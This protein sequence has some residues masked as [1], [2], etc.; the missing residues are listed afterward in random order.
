[1]A[2]S[3]WPRSLALLLALV[4]PASAPGASA[5]GNKLAAPRGDVAIDVQVG[6]LPDSVSRPPRDIPPRAV[7]G[8]AVV[9]GRVVDD[10]GT[11]IG[12]ARV[13]VPLP[14]PDGQRTVITGADGRY[15]FRNLP[16][17]TLLITATRTGYTGARWSREAMR[18]VT[19]GEG[20]VRDDVDLVLVRG[21]AIVGHVFDPAGEPLVGA[22]V[23]AHLARRA[24]RY[25]LP[26][27]AGSNDTTDDRGAF[28]LHSLAPGDYYVSV[29]PLRSPDG[30]EDGRRDGQGLAP[31]YH[32]GT[33][34]VSA[35]RAITVV[36]N[37]E[38]PVAMTVPLSP[39]FAVTG[40]VVDR[41]GRAVEDAS[42]SLRP[43]STIDGLP[44]SSGVSLRPGGAF[45]A[46]R[47]APGRYTLVARQFSAGGTVPVQTT[48]RPPPSGEVDLDVSSDIDGVVVRLTDGATVRGRVTF[49]STPPVDLTGVRVFVRSLTQSGFNP[50]SVAL[51]PD[52]TFEVA[53]LRGSVSFMVSGGWVP[54][55]PP[56]PTGVPGGVVGSILGPVVSLDVVGTARTPSPV[57]SGVADTLQ[58]T[59]RSRPVVGVGW[60]GGLP[61]PAAGAWRLRAMRANGQDVTD[62]G[63]DVGQDGLVTGVELEVAR[64][65]PFLTGVVRD[66][67]G[68]PHAGA[69]IVAMAVD[70]KAAGEPEG[71]VRALGRSLQDGRYFAANLPPGTW[72]LVALADVAMPSLV[73]D[74]EASVEWM[75]GRA[76]RVT[77]V[78]LQRLTLD[79]T[80]VRP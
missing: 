15:A 55:D 76:R 17:M 46:T 60:A 80:A 79:L 33:P 68:Q 75:R 16:R 43:R 22:S 34:D 58:S 12:G 59:A 47:V 53:G 61:F 48:Y 65:F 7:T 1:M 40:R 30:Y 11:P 13:R 28:R 26:P 27:S 78:E 51:T 73:E 32:P 38:S 3:S 23:R 10:Q 36:S 5:P 19:I 69:L 74:D 62:E 14:G 70:P 57:V 64:D 24:G 37:G 4:L 2:L 63:L 31:V 39:L 45:E 25:V 72:D 9:S 21:G 44:W 18:S 66:D 42:V 50:S 29:H 77:L 52:G 35:A 56:V 67:R 71:P 8:T 49:L 41:D 6:S 54:G 20:D